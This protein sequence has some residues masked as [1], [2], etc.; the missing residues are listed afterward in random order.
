MIFAIPG[1][2]GALLGCSWSLLSRS[3]AALGRSWAALGRSWPLLGRS[4]PL[5]R[6]SWSLLVA[7]GPLLAALKRSRQPKRKKT[8]PAVNGKRC[9]K[10]LFVIF[11]CLFRICVFHLFKNVY[12]LKTG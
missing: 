5:L 11:T 10:T 6:R 3:W 7:L 8:D 9:L 12:C 2:S 4:W 1:L